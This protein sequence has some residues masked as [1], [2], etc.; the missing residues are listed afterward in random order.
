M[1]NIFV[2]K[3]IGRK[4][5]V[6]ALELFRGLTLAALVEALRMKHNP[7]QYDFRTRY[8]CRELPA[9]ASLCYGAVLPKLLASI[10]TSRMSTTLSLLMSA[11]RFQFESC[12]ADPK[13]AD[14]T[15]ASTGLT[16][17]S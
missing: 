10:I 8:M 4:N 17:P 5:H 12:G 14:N 7:L 6:E 16:V 13:A 11:L 3:E 15:P 9:R 1:C 2:Q